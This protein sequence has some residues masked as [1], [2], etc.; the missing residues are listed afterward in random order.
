MVSEFAVL[1]CRRSGGGSV[2]KAPATLKRVESDVGWKVEGWVVCEL[3][4]KKSRAVELGNL[5][6][7]GKSIV[8]VPTKRARTAT[9]MDLNE[10]RVQRRS[11]RK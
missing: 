4:G 1:R 3:C 10:K 8:Q 9:M 11:H 6:R 7:P 5:R 2:S